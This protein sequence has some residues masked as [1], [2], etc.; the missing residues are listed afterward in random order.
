MT[1]KSSLSETERMLEIKSDLK[2]RWSD[3][4]GTGMELMET[5]ILG[6]LAGI[7]KKYASGELT[8]K[9][10]KHHYKDCSLNGVI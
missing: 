2:D 8:G 6:Y 4:L 1:L 5:M 9:D 7:M 10:K 3:D